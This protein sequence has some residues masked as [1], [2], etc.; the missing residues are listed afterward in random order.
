MKYMGAF[1]LMGNA[2]GWGGLTIE[3]GG[4]ARILSRMLAIFLAINVTFRVARKRV[5]NA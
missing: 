1:S 3:R 4:D 5:E 2:L